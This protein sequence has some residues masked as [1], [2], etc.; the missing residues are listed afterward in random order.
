MPAE[1]AIALFFC[2]LGV[3]RIATKELV[4]PLSCEHYLDP[5]LVRKLDRAVHWQ[6][7]FYLAGVGVFNDVN[8]LRDQLFYLVLRELAH[9]ELQAEPVCDLAR[10]GDVA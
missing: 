3:P 1:L 6:R 2:N 8:D 9:L 4:R 7:D 10:V 5:V